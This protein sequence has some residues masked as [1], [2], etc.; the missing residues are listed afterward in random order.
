M[1]HHQGGQA[2]FGAQPQ[3]QGQDLAAHRG[4]Q[5]GHRLVGDDEFG[6][7]DERARDDDT[8]ALAAGQL[9]R[10]A[11]EEAFRRAKSRP[12]EGFRDRRPLVAAVPVDAQ[13]LGDRVVHRVP[14]VERAAR[15]LEDQLDTFAVR[16]QGAGGV[17][18]GLAVERDA[19]PGRRDEAEQRAG[20]RRLAAARLADQGDDLAAPDVEVDPVNGTGAVGTVAAGEGDVQA[21]GTEQ[22]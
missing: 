14:G 12:G 22:R 16:L 17:V 15:V 4:V 8:L 10:V 18:E 1:G 6:L 9:V 2:E 20:Q 21:L 7:Q 11:Q 13:A 3:E 5:G 19:A